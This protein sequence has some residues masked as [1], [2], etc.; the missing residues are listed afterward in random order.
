M[1]QS[2]NKDFTITALRRHYTSPH[3]LYDVL[4]AHDSIY[5]DVSSQCWL[6]TGQA[7]VVTILGDSRFSSGLGANSIPQMASISK[8]M[9][10]MDGEMHQ[11]AQSVMLRPLAQMVKKMPADI[12]TFAHTALDSLQKTGEMDV[13]KEFASPVSLLAIAHVLGIPVHDQEELLQL[14][15]WSDTYSDVTS[16]YFRRDGM[17]DIS[18]LED[19]FRG[20]IET[21]RRS[22]SDDLLGAFIEAKDIFLDEEDLISNCMMVFAAGRVTT[23]KLLGNGI[24]VLL[25]QWE[26]LQTEF[27]GNP[28]LVPKLL[29]EELLRVVTPTRYLIRQACEDVDLSTQFPGNHLIRQGEKVLLF[30]EA[31]NHDPASFSLPEQFDPQRR[32]NRHIAFGHGNHQCPGATLARLEI[33]IAL[34]A[35]LSLPNLHPKPHTVP[36]WNPNPNLGGFTSYAVVFEPSTRSLF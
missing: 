7:P 34:A 19:Y 29:G 30:L 14:E 12:K 17:K 6:V 35:L 32:P 11:R 22:P 23:K 15:R 20:L 18:R 3:G 16:G 33:Q 28:K 13:V 4:R 8:Q 27:Q 25:R 10:F 24:P 5:F 21:K 26:Q 9:L 2:A 36:L 31:A 1:Y